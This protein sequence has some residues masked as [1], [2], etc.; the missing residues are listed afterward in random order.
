MLSYSTY[1]LEDTAQGRSS[2]ATGKVRDF[3][4]HMDLP[5]KYHRFYGEEPTR[6]LD[7]LARFVREEKIQTMSEE[8]A[9]I[10]FPSVL[11][12]FSKIQFEAGAQVLSAGD[13]GVASWPE[14]VQYLLRNYAQS[15]HISAAIT[16]LCAVRQGTSESENSFHKRINEAVAR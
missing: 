2:R 6:V 5:L 4:K 14:A 10:S 15:T 13:G 11:T 8:Q 12:G 3:I 1:R 9:F 7:F 16:D